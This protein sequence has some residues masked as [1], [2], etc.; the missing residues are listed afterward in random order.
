MNLGNYTATVVAGARGAK[1]G[2]QGSPWK[3]H[4]TR[5]VLACWSTEAIMVMGLK[6]FKG[7]AGSGVE[8]RLKYGL[9]S[10]EKQ[11][12]MVYKLKGDMIRAR[13]QK[14]MPE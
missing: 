9:H 8:L 12:L 3:G 13:L 5:L 11:P 6:D 14:H 1:T 2:R 7:E 4:K 10:L